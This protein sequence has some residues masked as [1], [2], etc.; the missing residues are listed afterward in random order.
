[1]KSQ[2]KSIPLDPVVK[3]DRLEEVENLAGLEILDPLDF[4]EHLAYLVILD[5]P[6][7]NLIFSHSWNK[8]RAHKEEKKDPH[9]IHFPTCKH[10]LDPLD[11]EDLQVMHISNAKYEL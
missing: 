8:S 5:H 10:L 9:Q 2:D 3:M 1:M 6:D 4:L 7:L 11:L